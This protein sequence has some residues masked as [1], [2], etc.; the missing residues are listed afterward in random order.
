MTKIPVDL[1]RNPL[2]R[3]QTKELEKTMS[4]I[5]HEELGPPSHVLYD[6]VAHEG[7]GPTVWEVCKTVSSMKQ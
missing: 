2:C 7:A 1:C 6:V 5:L 3:K 4:P